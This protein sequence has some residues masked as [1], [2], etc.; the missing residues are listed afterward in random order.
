MCFSEIT[1][2]VVDA[3][4]NS[5]SSYCLFCVYPTPLG[6]FLPFAKLRYNIFILTY[7]FLSSL[8]SVYFRLIRL[9]WFQVAGTLQVKILIGVK[10]TTFRQILGSLEHPCL[11]ED[12]DQVDQSLKYWFSF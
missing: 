10:D 8:N 1:F 12:I 7:I 4:G 3:I 2:E 6:G 11:R 5:L 9:F